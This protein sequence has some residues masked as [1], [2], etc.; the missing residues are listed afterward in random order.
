MKSGLLRNVQYWAVLLV[1]VA[2]GLIESTLAARAAD[3]RLDFSSMRNLRNIGSRCDGSLFLGSYEN[4]DSSLGWLV[5]LNKASQTGSMYVPSAMRRLERVRW[6]DDKVEFST[7]IVSYPGSPYSY[8][9]T[10]EI[11][12]A[13]MRGTLKRLDNVPSGSSKEFVVE[14]ELVGGGRTGLQQSGRFSNIEY[15]EDAGDLVGVELMLASKNRRDTK[16]II[17]F[18]IGYWGEDAF[19]PMLLNNVQNIGNQRIKFDLRFGNFRQSY[20]ITVYKDRAVLAPDPLPPGSM[21][22]RLT[23]PRSTKYLPSISDAAPQ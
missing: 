12:D 20:V 7:G 17:T 8:H 1:L 21:T 22:L 6:D 10:G 23:L 13:T 16:G 15:N 19:T 3:S 14:A 11:H 18:Y 5:C 9:F 4:G 2:S